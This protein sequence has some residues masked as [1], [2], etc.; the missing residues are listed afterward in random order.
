LKIKKSQSA[1]RQGFTLVEL[2]IV[3]AVL[4]ILAVVVLIAINP[5]EQFR[6][7]RDAGRA[8]TVAQLG[9]ALEAFAAAR[10]GV[11][12]TDSAVATDT[13]TD[14]TAPFAYNSSPSWITECLVD[15]GEIQIVPAAPV[16]SQNC[17]AGAD[18]ND[19]CLDADGG[20]AVVY[21]EAEALTNTQQCGTE[22]AYF[23]YNTS[24]GRGGLWCDNNQPVVN[25]TGQFIN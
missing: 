1:G 20:A 6:R 24:E 2:L 19:W 3:I 21:T 10:N 15:A 13:C 16:G 8:S 5:V 22:T 12:P 11:Y 9:H 7:T 18:Q 17:P 14:T 23:A 4:G 25:E